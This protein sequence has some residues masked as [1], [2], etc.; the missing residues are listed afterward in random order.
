MRTPRVQVAATDRN[1]KFEASVKT[2][3][4]VTAAK[5]GYAP[6]LARGK[7]EAVTLKLYPVTECA[8]SV[9]NGSCLGNVKNGNRRVG[10]ACS[11]G[12]LQDADFC[13]NYCF[14]SC[15]LP[16]TLRLVSGGPRPSRPLRAGR[17]ARRGGP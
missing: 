1:G 17:S 11:V 5:K 4:V 6:S 8:A 3:A 10:R 7:P 2:E 16:R 15:L 12:K 13:R 14:E 9:E